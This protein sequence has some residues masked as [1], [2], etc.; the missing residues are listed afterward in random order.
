MPMYTVSDEIK[1]QE[2]RNLLVKKVVQ[3]PS[4]DILSITLEKGALFPEHTSPRDA[5]LIVLEGA[6]EFYINAR[7]YTIETQQHFNFPKE[8]THWVKARENSKFV[9]IR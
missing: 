9:I 1:T 5:E 7:T 3:R 4:L 6:I 8:T 2:F